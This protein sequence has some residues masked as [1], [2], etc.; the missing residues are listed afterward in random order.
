MVR[1]KLSAINFQL[2]EAV[3]SQLSAKGKRFGQEVKI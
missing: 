2:K 1:K 3:S